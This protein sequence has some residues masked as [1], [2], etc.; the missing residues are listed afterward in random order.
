[1][2]EQQQWRVHF[3]HQE[4]RSEATYFPSMD[5]SASGDQSVNIP[6]P[7]RGGSV[8]RMVAMHNAIIPTPPGTV[9]LPDIDIASA[10][11]PPQ[12]PPISNLERLKMVAIPNPP[13][14][15]L[16]ISNLERLKMAV[17]PNPPFA[18]PPISN[19]ERLK[20]VVIPNPP[21]VAPALHM[22]QLERL[23][24]A[25]IPHLPSSRIEVTDVQSQPSSLT[26]PAFFTYRGNVDH[27]QKS[28]SIQVMDGHRQPFTIIGNDINQGEE[29]DCGHTVDFGNPDCGQLWALLLNAIAGD[30]PTPDEHQALEWAELATSDMDDD[31][32]RMLH[33]LKSQHGPDF[34][35]SD[36]PYNKDLDG[37]IMQALQW[38][39]ADIQ[40]LVRSRVQHV[41]AGQYRVV[42][43]PVLG[44]EGAGSPHPG[45][46]IMGKLQSHVASMFSCI[47][48]MQRGPGFVFPWWVEGS[49]QYP[50]DFQ[51]M[52][53]TRIFPTAHDYFQHT[54][55]LQRLSMGDQIDE[56]M[57]EKWF[58]LSRLLGFQDA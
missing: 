4:S 2:S 28:T 10:A 33:T 56:W 35:P 29:P 39:A 26:V 57:G 31:F 21:S 18:T 58:A 42:C 15:T 48:T 41:Q 14:V 11:S 20:M 50:V 55:P 43:Q 16:P 17:I 8:D 3:Y 23:H 54:W 22:D 27:P 1:M 30:M 49:P 45:D 24:N 46:H 34:P 9:T 13:S 47:F 7:T 32:L 36:I 40:H 25:M 37:H 52:R 19:L 5:A 12:P 6:T 38:I 53:G 51:K 44:Y